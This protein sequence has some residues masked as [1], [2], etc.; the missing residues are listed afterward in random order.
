MLAVLGLQQPILQVLSYILYGLAGVTL[1]YTVYTIVIY[2][3]KIKTATVNV[4]S[5]SAF[6]KRI[7]NHYGFRT[8]IFAGV[9]LII[10]IIYVAFN[11]LLA[12]YF[13]SIWYGSLAG[14]YALLIALRSGLVFYHKGK[15]QFSEQ[16]Q[17]RV[18]L[19]K[20]K[21]CGII[22]TIV[23]VCLSVAI[24]QM[25]AEGK[26]FEHWSWTAIAFAAYAFYKIIM[27]IVLR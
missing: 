27:A 17:K 3:P 12:L 19:K 8:V 14:Y 26:A 10:N 23:P 4:I 9:S 1:G 25:V 21:S 13:G 16:E 15:K 11:V 2:A 7:L 24:A 5:K 20:Y 22:L 6:G 18:E